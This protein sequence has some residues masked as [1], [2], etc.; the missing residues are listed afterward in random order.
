MFVIQWWVSKIYNEY[1]SNICTPN[2]GLINEY[3][4][5]NNIF[6]LS[7]NLDQMFYNSFVLFLDLNVYRRMVI[8]VNNTT[9]SNLYYPF[10]PPW[11]IIGNFYSDVYFTNSIFKNSTLSSIAIRIYVFKKCFG[12]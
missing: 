2:D 11:F 5:E 7:N 9:F 4:F 3:Q 10:N 1:C 6:S 12:K 8:T